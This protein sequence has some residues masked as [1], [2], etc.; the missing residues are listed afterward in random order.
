MQLAADDR[1][2]M[3]NLDD[4]LYQEA[5]EWFQESML[6]GQEEGDA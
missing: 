3:L 2:G 5:A 6:K 4:E 1:L